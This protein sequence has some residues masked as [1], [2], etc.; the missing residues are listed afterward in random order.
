MRCYIIDDQEHAIVNLSHHIA[1]T[2]GLELVGS[3]MDAVSGVR[4]I[5]SGTVQTDIV[6]LDID[7]PDM[8]GIEV[9]ERVGDRAVVIFVTAHV[10]YAS[11]AIDL[12]A[13]G[14][15]SKPVR[16]D[17]FLKA[18]ERARR[19]LGN[20][21]LSHRRPDSVFVRC[22]SNHSYQVF[23]MDLIWL[24]ASNKYV[25]LYTTN[26]KPLMVNNTLSNF[27]MLLPG[28]EFVRIHKSHI[29]NLKF[30]SRI[31]FNQ[32]ILSN[33][34]VLDIGPTYA[35]SLRNRLNEL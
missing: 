7:M 14:Y 25:L 9:A 28:S 12:G 32:V 4:K 10:D 31:V 20:N 21:E 24:K 2:P 30:V 29:I 22:D 15:L 23:L 17:K 19:W 3:D 27:E 13:V 16:S 1:A 18:I 6:F 26:A 35:S 34:I 11:D 5:V 8:D 33:D